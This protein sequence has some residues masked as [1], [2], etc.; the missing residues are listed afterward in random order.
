MAASSNA[1]SSAA[2]SP[3]FALAVAKIT[4]SVVGTAIVS[5]TPGSILWDRQRTEPVSADNPPT[6][7]LFLPMWTRFLAFRVV[8]ETMHELAPRRIAHPEDHL[9]LVETE[10]SLA[11]DLLVRCGVD[12]PP[13]AQPGLC[14]KRRIHFFRCRVD[15]NLVPKLRHGMSPVCSGNNAA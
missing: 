14:G 11:A 8:P 10:V 4:S 9:P 7:Q 1:A 6:N 3:G 13:A 2:S 5:S 15:R 12:G